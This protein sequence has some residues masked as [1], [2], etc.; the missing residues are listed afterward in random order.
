[1]ARRYNGEWI[2]ASGPLAFDLSDW[3]ADSDGAPYL[4]TLTRGLDT[5]SAC[6]CTTFSNEIALPS[7]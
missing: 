7:P 3:V 6:T 1:M 4:G 5:I 2:S